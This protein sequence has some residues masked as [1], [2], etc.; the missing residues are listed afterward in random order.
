MSRQ[1]QAE[2]APCAVCAE[3]IVVPAGGTCDE[4]LA[5]GEEI[6]KALA[7]WR[8]IKGVH[9]QQ[10]GDA[11]IK[12]AVEPT[13]FRRDRFSIAL[14]RGEGPDYW[15][16]RGATL[17]EAVGLA[18]KA[19]GAMTPE[20]IR[21]GP[22][23]SWSALER[24]QKRAASESFLAASGLGSITDRDKCLTEYYDMT[25]AEAN[26]ILAL[27]KFAHPRPGLDEP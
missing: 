11:L 6:T 20:A 15:M 24:A 26:Q 5:E 16:V 8:M 19:S 27:D 25:Q 12:M 17:S 7:L 18:S 13:S 2:G 4:C 14:E 23:L 10:F 1:E 22:D 9:A 21:R 3:V